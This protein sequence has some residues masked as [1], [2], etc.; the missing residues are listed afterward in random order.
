[1][2]LPRKF[3]SIAKALSNQS[4]RNYTIG[5]ICCHLGMWSYRITLQWL[6]W[7]LT[8]S[9]LWLGVIAAADLLPTVV[10]A[11]LA[12]ALTERVNRLFFMKLAIGFAALQ[13]LCLSAL[14]FLELISIW[15]VFSFTL[16]LGLILAF[17]HPI[18]LV[19]VPN[20][21]GRE[22][23]ASAV[24][25]NSLVFNIARVAGPA[26][27]GGV[28]AWAGDSLSDATFGAGMVFTFNWLANGVFV[29]M[30]FLVQIHP[31]RARR[32]Q[33]LSGSVISDIKA[34]FIYAF[35][36][37]GLGRILFILM[38]TS[39]CGRTFIDLFAAVVDRIFS[40]GADALGYLMSSVGLGAVCAGF[41][42][43]QR[44]QITGLTRIVLL[45][46]LVL[47]IALVIFAMTDDF[48]IAVLSVYVAGFSLTVAGTGEQTLIQ[49]AVDENMRG[50]VVSL[51]GAISRGFPSLGAIIMGGLGDLLG[52]R[53]PLLAGAGV[54]LILWLWAWKQ[55][56]VLQRGLETAP[57]AIKE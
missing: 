19:I 32:V 7:K 6:T 5:N 31:E 24:A 35:S 16:A 4:Y 36:H 52:L 11:P 42:L 25:I 8:E 14:C 21:V 17:N 50:R 12:G 44:G 1:M 10:L 39:L 34:G 55:R 26:I 3:G 15:V 13:S 33:A 2:A 49:A 46:I 37:P 9:A 23:L 30:L 38:V 53:W 43:A 41:W 48:G 40:G 54:C 45:S 20:I 57:D 47:A 29:V 27:A 56:A 51:Y 18:R 22:V 28:L